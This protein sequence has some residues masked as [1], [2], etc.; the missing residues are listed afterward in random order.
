MLTSV[1]SFTPEM[2]ERVTEYCTNSSTD[3]SSNMNELWD[4]TVQEFEDADKMSSPLQGST[5]KFLAG[6]LQPKRIL[7]IG[8]YS[9]YSAL[10]WH[11]STQ[12]TGAD[13]VTLELD[14]N[15]IAATRRTLEKYALSDRVALI[16]GD[17]SESLTKLTGSFDLIFVDANKDGYEAY[18][19]TILD[20]K[21]LSPRGLIMADNIFARGMTISTESNPGLPEKVRGYWTDNG[22]ALRKF[23][24]FCKNDGR[25]DTVLLPVYDGLTLIKWK[26]S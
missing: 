21:L 2:A 3:V 15:M 8:S 20:R 22:K 13:I 6:L 1:L 14:K 7:E 4:W 5:M 11:E 17:A 24:T 9:G 18:V 10:A 23:N 12:Q 25:I 26:T 19:K 16:E